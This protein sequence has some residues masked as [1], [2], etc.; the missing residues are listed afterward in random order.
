MI[1]AIMITMVIAIP[2]ALIVPATIATVVASVVLVPATLAFRVQ[3][4]SPLF[5]YYMY[6]V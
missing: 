6:S 1:M 3:I 4:S 2:V 5:Y